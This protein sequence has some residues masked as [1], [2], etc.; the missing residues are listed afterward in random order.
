LGRFGDDLART[1]SDDEL[2]SW[3]V[4]DLASIF[5]VRVDLVETH[6]ARWLDAMPQYG[7][8]HGA[9]VEQI[10]ASLPDTL[11]VAGNYLYGIGVPACI[12]SGIA[13]AERLLTAP[14]AR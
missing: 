10:R 4:E 3:A 13:A 8:G 5:G 6:V 1:A 14:V 2:V 12:A 7:P 9:V 11:A